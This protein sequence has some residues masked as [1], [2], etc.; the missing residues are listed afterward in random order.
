MKVQ[1]A[2]CLDVKVNAPFQDKFT[3]EKSTFDGQNLLASGNKNVLEQ[4]IRNKT[5]VA[6]SQDQP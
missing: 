2:I 4:S 6:K 5:T 1:F 3:S